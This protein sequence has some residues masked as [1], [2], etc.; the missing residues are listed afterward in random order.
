[1]M[2]SIGALLASPLFVLMY[3]TQCFFQLCSHLDERMVGKAVL[4][5]KH[6]QV[7][8]SLTFNAAATL[9]MVPYTFCRT[10]SP[11]LYIKMLQIH[12]TCLYL[13]IVSSPCS[14]QFTLI[15]YLLAPCIFKFLSSPILSLLNSLYLLG[16]T[17]VSLFF[18]I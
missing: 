16:P 3:P 15:T 7:S 17:E 1:M 13:F 10:K 12:D 5:I 6:F 18:G 9:C 11:Y 2:L 4:K 14:V 8:H